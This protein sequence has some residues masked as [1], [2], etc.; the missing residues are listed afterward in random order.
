MKI[1]IIGWILAGLL[2]SACHKNDSAVE[3]AATDARPVTGG[4]SRTEVRATVDEAQKAIAAKDFEKAAADIYKVSQQKNLSQDEA[5]KLR[6]LNGNLLN[7]AQNDPKAME[8]YKAM[9]QA[10][11]AH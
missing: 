5:D 4:G 10:L 3:G 11:N 8:A 9:S 6:A 7:A 1:Q 2:L